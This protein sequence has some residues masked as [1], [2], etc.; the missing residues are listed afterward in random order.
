[1]G[2]ARLLLGTTAE[3]VIR[4][5]HCPVLVARKHAKSGTI[6]VATDLSEKAEPAL[7]LAAEVATRRKAKLVAVHALDLLP[8]PAI[9]VMVPFGGLPVIPPPELVKQAHEAAGEVLS[10]VL[11]RI[12]VQ[13]EPRVIEGDAATAILQMAD[14]IG[15][16]L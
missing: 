7:R 5:A 14:E 1:T 12:G 15:A 9:G 16:E 3:R 8:R 6:L 13:G 11:E 4:Y 2:I 10:A